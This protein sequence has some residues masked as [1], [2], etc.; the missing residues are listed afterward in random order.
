MLKTLMTVAF[1]TAS[2]LSS[3][4]CSA[5]PLTEKIEFNEFGVHSPT[6]AAAADNWGTIIDHEYEAANY[7][8]DVNVSFWADKTLDFDMNDNDGTDLFFTLFNSNATFQTED[9]DLVVNQGNIGIIHER[10][11]E[12][13]LA[14]NRCTDP[15]DRYKNGSPHGGFVFAKFSQAVNLHS[16]LL[17][18][19]EGSS[20]QRGEIAFFDSTQQ[21]I[22]NWI[23][24]TVTG[25]GGSAVQNFMPTQNATYMV[26]RMQGSGGFKNI[27]FSKAVAVPEP[28]MLGV[29]VLGLMGI[30]LLRTRRTL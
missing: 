9:D 30:G 4:L 5:L 15:D 20:N 11:S 6:S 29:L 7:F 26:M 16:I 28:A 13:S 3:F 10:N 27:E 2:L 19:I 8:G 12:C 24:M 17:A 1:G 18:D 14:L 23:D 22:G 21:V 25:N